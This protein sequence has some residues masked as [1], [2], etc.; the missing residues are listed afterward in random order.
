MAEQIKQVAPLR[1]VIDHYGMPDDSIS[2]SDIQAFVNLINSQSHIWI[3]LSASD[4]LST[5]NPLETLT[6]D[7]ADVVKTDNQQAVLPYRSINYQQLVEDFIHS[8]N[9]SN[10]LQKIFVTNPLYDF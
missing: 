7:H 9:D 6:P 8:I 3:K 4:R 2:S 1:V 10:L 5:T